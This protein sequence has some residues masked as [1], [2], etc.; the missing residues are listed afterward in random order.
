MFFCKFCKFLRTPLLQNTTGRLL[1]NRLLLLYYFELLF[2]AICYQLHLEFLFNKPVACYFFDKRL[3]HR[4]F[5]VNLAKLS[6]TPF[7]NTTLGLL[8]L[9]LLNI[10]VL[11]QDLMLISQTDFSKPFETLINVEIYTCEIKIRWTWEF[12]LFLPFW[13]C[14]FAIKCG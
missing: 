10:S 13:F 12:V 5:L 8:L 2:T 6:K 7:L 11:S 3:P 9:C 4:W 1:R 14:K